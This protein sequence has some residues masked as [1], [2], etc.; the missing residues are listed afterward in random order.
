MQYFRKTLRISLS[1]DY[2]TIMATYVARKP[3]EKKKNESFNHVKIEYKSLSRTNSCL[4][5]ML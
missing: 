4:V 2:L 1:I 5:F 3:S